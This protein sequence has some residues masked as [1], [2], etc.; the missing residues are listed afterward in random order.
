[1]EQVR[2][3]ESKVKKQKE[4]ENIS[5]FI[6]NAK[7]IYLADYSGIKV[8]KINDLR[9]NFRSLNVKFRVVKNTFFT[10]ALKSQGLKV[11]ENNIKGPIAIAVSDDE[12]VA[13]KI[14]TEFQK[15]NKGL[16][17]IRGGILEGKEVTPEQTATLAEL[18]GRKEMFGQLIALILL[19]GSKISLIMK[20]YGG[21]IL[22]A[23]NAFVEKLEREEKT[24]NF[25]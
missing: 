10:Q 15:K 12:I 3:G 9:K 19:P 16:L 13:L 22:S 5:A 23:V 18:P 17:S 14:I 7:S 20:S 4:I 1:M 24:S 8:E 6:K 21:K 2:V 25:I 11:L